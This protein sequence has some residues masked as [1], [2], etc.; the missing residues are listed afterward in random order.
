LPETKSCQ[1]N[2][3]SGADPIRSYSSS[4]SKVVARHADEKPFGNAADE[5]GRDPQ[6]RN[7]RPV[8]AAARLC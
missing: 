6:R 8:A 3:S 2:A 5:A 1:F 4:R 7:L